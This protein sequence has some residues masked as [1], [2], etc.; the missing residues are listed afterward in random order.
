MPSSLLSSQID[1]SALQ[2]LIEPY[3]YVTATPGKDIR[4]R[5]IKAFNN[6]LNVDAEK[7]T[8]ITKVT[9]MLHSASLL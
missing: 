2:A 6:W 1:C 4:G 8:V 3:K 7:L 9:A 5:L